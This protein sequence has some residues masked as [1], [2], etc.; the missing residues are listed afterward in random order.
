[1]HKF[2]QKAAKYK[3]TGIHLYVIQ[4]QA[5]LFLITTPTAQATK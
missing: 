2:E 1:M 4:K 5:R 3:S